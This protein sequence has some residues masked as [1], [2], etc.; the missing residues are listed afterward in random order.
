MISKPEEGP[1]GCVAGPAIS[2]R[3]RR[4]LEAARAHF[5]AHGLERASLDAIAAHARVSKMT[6]Y[7]NFG[8]KEGLFEAVVRGRTDRVMAGLAGVDTHDPQRPR[9]VEGAEPAARGEPGDV[10]GRRPRPQLAHA[11]HARR[12]RGQ[13]AAARALA[14]V[15]CR[16]CFSPSE[17]PPASD[18]HASGTTSTLSPLN[19]TNRIFRPEAAAGVGRNPASPGGRG[20][21]IGARRAVELA[22]RSQRAI[23]PRGT[24]SQVMGRAPVATRARAA[25]GGPFPPPAS[26]LR[27]G[28]LA[29]CGGYDGA[30]SSLATMP[31]A[32]CYQGLPVGILMPNS[33]DAVEA[34]FA[35]A[36]LGAVS[37]LMNS[38]IRS[39]TASEC[40]A[41]SSDSSRKPMSDDRPRTNTGNFESSGRA[42]RSCRSKSTRS[43]RMPATTTASTRESSRTWRSSRL[44]AS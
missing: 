2:E 34:I 42:S 13:G 1:S 29:R 32:R 36:F 44:G 6:V 11:R 40:D 8:S 16:L 30:N 23:S 10:H 27:G 43:L 14:G 17:S 20:G 28:R 26:I 12:P 4:V 5:H 35:T 33:A 41:R 31:P 18:P 39:V 25:I 22:L 7:S 24:V 3:S 15:P 9:K 37:V 38:D 19:C 21:N